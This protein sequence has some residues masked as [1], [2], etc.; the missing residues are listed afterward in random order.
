MTRLGLR[1]R[2]TV[3][4]LLVLAVGVGAIGVGLNVLLTRRLSSDANAVLRARADAQKATIGLAGG[5]VVVREGQQDET[6]DREAWVFAGGRLVAGPPASPALGREAAT[7]S[8]VTRTTVRDVPGEVRLL[9][10]PAYAEAGRRIATV[11]VGVSLAPYEDTERAARLGTVAFAACVLLGGSLIARRAV[12]A[13]LRPVAAMARAAEDYGEHD[14]SKRF[15]LGPPRDEITGLA[16]TLDGLLDR[17]QASLAREQRLTAEIAHEL[18][19]PLSGIRAEAELALLGGEATPAVGD[20]LRAV[21]AEADRMNAA[22]EALLAAAGR[23]GAGSATCELE[24][25]LRI[26]LAAGASQARGKGVDLVAPDAVPGAR[27]GADAAFVA[28]VLQPL[29]DNAIRHARSR[30]VVRAERGGSSVRVAIEDDGP[31]IAAG[32]ETRIFEAGT[33]TPGGSGAGLGLA[34]S[35]RLARSIGGDVHADPVTGGARLVAELRVVS[36]GAGGG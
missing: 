15:G 18:R 33:H 1:G 4:S 36:R 12:G 13:G 14:L 24:E 21:V 3:A 7:L 32:E 30:V 27:V 26:A 10:E 35:R 17:L 8:R 6:L 11:V 5:R 9:A 20:A 16:A 2:V 31:G 19:T 28:Q 34:L 29:L 22:I 25:P 23:G